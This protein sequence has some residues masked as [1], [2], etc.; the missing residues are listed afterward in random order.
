MIPLSYAQQRLWFFSRSD[1]SPAYNV[2]FALR[3][4]GPLDH[5]ALAAALHD[6]LTRHEALRTVF[7]APDGQPR[8]HILDP[9]DLPSGLPTVRTEAGEQ[10]R[11]AL[12]EAAQEVFDLATEVPF[13]ARLFEV[14]PREEHVLLLVMHHIVSDGGSL[15]PL[16]RDLGAA[17]TARTRGHAPGW[18]ELPVQ[19]A[20][21]TL[22]QQEMLGDADD[23]QSVLAAQLDH[24]H[25]AL[26][27]L[28][29]EVTLPGERRRP[30]V[31]SHRGGTVPLC[32]GADVHA[33]V[34]ELARETG[35]TVFMVLH[36]ALAALL[37]RLG[38]GTDISL[39]TPVSGRDDEALEDLVGFFVNTVVLRT[40]TSGD[41]S[42][43]TLLDRVRATDLAAYAHQ[44]VPFD[45]LV[46]DLNPARAAGR[47]PL[48]QVMLVLTS[49][50]GDGEKISAF[51]GLDAAVE[52][53]GT[54]TA[55]FDLTFGVT[56][57]HAA[58][59]SPA[60]L[61]WGIGYATDLFD[62]ATVTVLA[63]RLRH[64]LESMPADPDRR[65][66]EVDPTTAEESAS[67]EEWGGANAP[68]VRPGTVCGRFAEQV[69][70]TPDAVALVDRGRRLRFAELQD[71]AHRFGHLLR[72][73]DVGDGDIVALHLPRSADLV[74]CLLGTLASGAAYTLLDPDFPDARLAEVVAATR[75][76]LI[77]TADEEPSWLG[78][79]TAAVLRLPDLWAEGATLP[80]TPPRAGLSPDAP[81]CVMFTSGSTGTPKGVVAPHRA[82][83]GTLCDQ[84]Y[85]PFGPGEVW[86]QCA[87]VSWD[88]FAT[89]LLG[90]LMGGATCV[91][92]PGQRPDPLL[93]AQLAEEH[94][95][96]VL[97]AS[98]GL[99]NLLV[100]EHPEIL[101]RLRAAF[102]GGE[103]A[104]VAHVARLLEDFGHI[105]VGNGYGP[106]E[107]MGF[108]TVHT[109][110]A[111]DVASGSVPVG[112]PVRG[113][114]AQVLD[115][116]LRRVPPGVPG[117]L[118]LSGT[119]L[120][121]G[122]LGRPG[123]TAERFV[124]DP[125]GP[126]GSRMYRTGD[127]VRWRRDGVLEYLGRTDDQVK[128]RGFR[129]EPAEVQAALT[130]HPGVRQAVVRMRE[131]RP[132]DPRLVAYVVP[133]G[134]DLPPDLA[135]HAAER[136]PA[137]LVPAAYVALEKLPL[138][139]NGKLDHR[140]L[141]APDYAAPRT[142]RAPRTAREEIV[143]GLF[144]E[145]LGL[146]AVGAE[147]DFFALGG[148]SLLA[149]RLLSRARAALGVELTVG[150]LFRMPTPA[151]LAAGARTTGPAR[152]P[153]R[154]RERGGALPLSYAQQ[155]LWFLTDSEDGGT[156]YN[157]PYALRL[158]GRLDAD[159][160]AA[161]LADLT[162][163]HEVLRTVFPQTDG[164]PR[165]E[166]LPPGACPLPVEECSRERLA[167]RL[168]EAAGR[169]FDLASEPPFAAR[170][171][172]SAP[173][174]HVL[175]LVLHHIASDGWSR[176]VL[177]RDLGT[178]YTA[179]SNGR[180]PDWDALPV[181]YADYTLWQR[182]LLGDP[183]DPDSLLATQ[184]DHWRHTLAGL[185]EQIDLPAAGSGAEPRDRRGAVVNAEMSA[186]T[187][188]RVVELA[189]ETGTTVF[190]VLH[191]ALAATLTRLGAGTDIPLGTPVAGR[192][193]Q[194]LDDLVGFFVNT[195]VLRT[196]TSG[197]PTFRTLL[198][199][200]RD[201]DLTAY[202]HQD[203]PFDRVVEDLNPARAAGRNPL[204]Q[205]MLVLQNEQATD[206]PG[207]QLGELTA[208][209][210]PVGTG[211][212]KFDLTFAFTDRRAADGA[213]AGLALGLEYAGGLFD[214]ADAAALAARTAR[215]LAAAT[216][217]PDQPLGGIDVMDTEE[218]HRTLHAWNATDAP[219]E[220]NRTV[221]QRIAERAAH[222]PTAVAVSDG[223]TTV[224]YAELNSR[225]D[226]LAHL[227]LGIGV[228][229][230]SVVGVCLERSADMVVT[231]L[232]TLKAGAAYVPLDPRH[233][234]DRLAFVL[235]D[236]AAS[237]VVSC[238][239][240]AQ[241]FAGT[242]P[243]TVSGS[244]GPRLLLLDEEE[245]RLRAQPHTP[246]ATE[247]GGDDAAY[248][249]YTSG[250]TGRPKGVVVE[251][252]A[253]ADLVAWHNDRYAVTPED[254]AGQ[255]AAAGF[256]AAVWEVWPY[257]CAGAS[258]HLP[259]EDVLDDP[260]ALAAWTADTALTLCFLSTPR[261]ETVLDDPSLASG[262]LRAVLTGGDAL[263]RRPAP[264]LPFRVVNHYGPTECTVVA[265][266]GDV[267]A[268]EAADSPDIGRPVD[269]TRAYVLDERLGAVP[270]GVVG[271]LY[272]AGTGL[273]RGYLGRPG[274]TAGR[275]V[276]C[277][278]GAPG[279]RMYR[280]G[281]LVRWG[282]DGTLHF[283]GRADR[284]VKIRGVRIELGE[285]EAALA[286]RPEVSQ[287]AV[288]VREDRPGD[289][290]LVGYVVA[291]EAST[292]TLRD[293]LR[294]TLPAAMVPADLV[295]LEAFPLTANGKLDRAALPRPLRSTGTRRAP[296]TP[297]EQILCDLF[298]ELLDVP[299]GVGPDDDFFALG[300]HSLL[301]G[302]LIARAG[303]ALGAGLT[304]RD[305]FRAPTPA[306]LAG[307]A[308]GAAP[309]RPPL[310]TG[311]R[312]SRLPLSPA[313]RRL[314]F[315]NRLDGGTA[316]YAVPAA[317]RLRGVLDRRA[318]EQALGDVVSRHEALRTVF[319]EEAGEPHQ[320]V[321][322][323]DAARPSLDVSGVA[324]SGW[325]EVVDAL[326]ARPFDVTC[327]LPFRAALVER[328]PEDHVLVMVMHHIVSDGWSFGP[329]LRDLSDA[330][331]ARAAG[332]ESQ[333][334][335]LPVQYADYALW[336]REVL[337]SED[338]PGSVCAGQLDHW[339]RAL[340]GLPD[341]LALPAD[342][343]RPAVADHGAG[344]V[345][346]E[347][348]AALHRSVA[349]LARAH[350]VTLF[351][352]AHAALA[353]L[354]TR[355]GAGT[356]VPVGT[357]VAGRTDPALDD[358]VGFFVNT[359]VLRADTDGNPRFRELLERVRETDLTAFSHQ[360]LPFERLVEELNPA[361]SLARH[362]LVQVLLV[363]QNTGSAPLDLPG[364]R[365]ED[366][367]VSGNGTSFDL[368]VGLRE[369]HSADGAPAGI[370]A[371]V[372]YRADL[373][374]HAT[375]A[376]IAE[377]LRRLLAAFAADPDLRLY[378]VDL[379]GEDE[380]R[381]L[382]DGN[383]TAH[384]VAGTTLPALFAAQV[385]RT[386]DAVAVVFEDETLTYRELDARAD[387]LARRLRRRGAGPEGCVAVAL[388]RS[389]DLVV[390]LYAVHKAG[391]AYLP[392]DPDYPRDR[393]AAMLA[394]A[395]PVVHLTPGT[396]REL[397]DEAPSSSALTVV[398]PRHPAYVIYTSGS[399]GRPKG[400]TVP[401]EAIV[402]RL[403]WMQHA[404]GLTAG[405][406]VLQKTPSSFD[407]SVWEFFWPLTVGAT[408]VVAR[409]GGHREPEY[410]A[411]LVRS[412]GI[413]TLHFVPSM[414][415]AF[416]AEPEAAHCPSLRRVV[417]SGEA[418][419][420][421]LAERCARVLGPS[422]EIHNLYGPTEAAVDVTA[423]RF[424]GADTERGTP[425]VPLG[426]PVWNTRVHVLDRWLRPV[427][428]G[429]P[430]ELY[431]A[432][433]QLARG[434]LGQPA[435]T[436]GRFVADPHGPAGERMY[437]TGDL[438][439][440]HRDGVLEFLGRTD[441]QVK[442]RGFRI[443]P[444][445]VAQALTGHP[446][447]HRAAVV[448]REDR[449][450]DLRLVAYVVGGEDAA[451]VRRYAA[452]TLPAHMVPAAVVPVPEIPVS[453]SGKLD[454]AALPAPRW[455]T[456]GAKTPPR[457]ARERRLCA[458]YSGLL[459]TEVSGVDDDFFAL[460]GHSLLAAR[461]LHAVREE[462]GVDPGLGTLFEAPTVAELAA[463]IGRLL[464][465]GGQ[466]A[467]G[468][469]AAE[470]LDV[471]LPLRGRTAP[472]QAPLFCVHPAAGIGWV[473]SSLLR[474]LDG[475]RPVYA[476]Q[477]RGLT[478]D[479]GPAT[480]L[481]EM[482]EDYAAR[483]REV[484]PHGPYHLLGWSFG[485]L[486][487]HALATRLQGEGEPVDLLA[488]LDGYPGTGTPPSAA[489]AAGSAESLTALLASLG[490]RP[491]DHGRTTLRD[492]AERLAGVGPLAGLGPSGVERLSEVFA[493]NRGLLG[494]FAP[495]RFDG[496]MDL[497]VATA[498]KTA[499]S[500]APQ[501]WLP[502]VGGRLGVHRVPCRHGE[503]ALP[504]PAAR[505]GEVL[506]SRLRQVPAGAV[507]RPG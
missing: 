93:I 44:D 389:L 354:L 163:R 247:V 305:L 207:A 88:A 18:D 382:H 126:P 36:A 202:A 92:Q 106:A 357:P 52:P 479:T 112:R 368:T 142:G 414:L 455:A 443:E 346:V 429:V 25:G 22:W 250:S 85:A 506:A 411:R 122:Y 391:A 471:L 278:F 150:D 220:E 48:F 365:V 350:G 457:D 469:R 161:A 194:A 254:R 433:T 408:L 313:Q 380:A 20:D 130:A 440:R 239:D 1:D 159:G 493:N 111:G 329:L 246:V 441:D 279:A 41:P 293:H 227:L 438:V 403:C 291:P 497:F 379:L 308:L 416:L 301:A 451:E 226:R 23:P 259:A 195:L 481:A 107:S 415:E 14:R 143:C 138:T 499:D 468:T 284:Q 494:E 270:P 39:G 498:D 376:G 369:R 69:A 61:D 16:L 66:S 421:A 372:G 42:F 317:F 320:V 322:A 236:T 2:P 444:G 286:S 177:L 62:A 205:T 71:E 136:L 94:G 491:P 196:D 33:R 266:A 146:D 82:L 439:R 133:H 386:P 251:H 224:G 13:R 484:Q 230:G 448:L 75:P 201:T 299:D 30:G 132:G 294:D 165:Q 427:P 203:L 9:G 127:L 463:R 182:E 410:L 424:T 395:A 482:V 193:D 175:L 267:A 32:L 228:G 55:K 281:D 199:R 388:P 434:Y 500:P 486:V 144:A 287:A 29:E 128:I 383:A 399:T 330:Y 412:R 263:R 304:V 358:L 392:V 407:V 180:S 221:P 253:L 95:A 145:A 189:R 125:Y 288:V 447:V 178:A 102:T 458:L 396:L 361:R 208:S 40:D 50:S 83:T 489:P 422:V 405:E 333:G 35:T 332:R 218:R 68:V 465:D 370:E 21:Y 398:T 401:H 290:R 475:E 72:A 47:N 255:T 413:T 275:F 504:G 256:D 397:R 492:V 101:P 79:S 46:E 117:E 359:L 406:A 51:S 172:R 367:P 339:R 393:V 119:G 70:R 63:Q 233:P 234:A 453:P 249:I 219:R 187:H 360:D 121:L 303:A 420:T 129:V 214:R 156:T 271:E 431:L 139:A 423:H 273:A 417:C 59:G 351:M 198:N 352:V 188:A 238:R 204:F 80:A 314:W 147:D 375:A 442:L 192:T 445:E 325:R 73:R 53:I 464:D 235:A 200:V 96:T 31:P 54:G 257:L 229:R 105:R 300:G 135:G 336:Q 151:A 285:I 170:L 307:L 223:T 100:D 338:D 404:Y 384:E 472:E 274:L 390:A 437:R 141:P 171:F 373:F 324:G 15:Q 114:R 298:A 483:I 8:Q 241:T 344:L 38:A 173:D 377:R 306:S 503:L 116:S 276:A 217:D 272:L 385:R 149:M 349:E 343:P 98:A 425:T 181:Q 153:L 502:H 364:V 103:A 81:A 216:A 362:P 302:R 56:E 478:G 162:A 488:V 394:D 24:W 474:H 409:P 366:V 186:A 11:Q 473:Y 340:A 450:G 309:A 176:E 58:D 347:W 260:A 108:S 268:R 258:V 57:R 311:A 490:H 167:A 158:R 160:L 65:L 507:G 174:D 461:L 26:A 470:G 64:V 487:A 363:L 387:D 49:G 213:P 231:L 348:D 244:P 501:L 319:P 295:P 99:F 342:R 312:P 5:A 140:A 245:A 104:S 185:P 4:T 60:G 148:H 243:E 480:R 505:I 28:P 315:L 337:G 97:K 134:G 430:G 45:R 356:D 264:G 269:N 426:T 454:R 211:E 435:L 355:L 449:P 432:G 495:E 131:D 331:A 67:L 123:A 77:V 326:V 84:D 197:N 283:A 91:L 90:P 155:R 446:G 280:T 452:A 353:A 419:P 76:A 378:D 237:L 436:A 17:Y 34:V 3:L 467:D 19:Y 371:G 400:V 296:R 292:R 110:T 323:A 496:P 7:P 152:P 282:R 222:T 87:P 215:L 318:L 191:A 166:V 428:P 169:V 374:D 476:L 113:K 402:N 168:H 477:A 74:T 210:E 212:V 209:W 462:F 118:H 345:S 240:L 341:E 190:M 37:T 10:L 242:F 261:L 252:R 206:A 78:G 485:G 334:R 466:P 277:P 418:L 43:R 115:G 262:R 248:V 6:V 124:A 335:P 232:A 456:D 109:A 164:V 120:A 297:R 328:A 321:V 460:G 86:L 89:E 310:R 154:P 316:A 179:R 459:G 137:H 381:A 27:G 157:S 12:S 289:R 184:L 327:D 265:T 183:H 225:A